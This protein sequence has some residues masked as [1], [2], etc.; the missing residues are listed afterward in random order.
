MP[1]NFDFLQPNWATLHDDARQ[2]EQNVFAAPRTCAVYGGRIA[3]NGGQ[4]KATSRESAEMP[5]QRKTWW[6][7]VW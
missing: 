4:E 6:V 3:I 5:W 7:S 2:A 1:S